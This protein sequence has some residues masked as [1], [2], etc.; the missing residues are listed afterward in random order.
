MSSRDPYVTRVRASKETRD[1]DP[2][3]AAAGLINLSTRDK[4]S[5]TVSTCDQ[6]IQELVTF[7]SRLTVEQHTIPSVVWSVSFA[8][9]IQKLSYK[10]QNTFKA[11]LPGAAAAAPLI[12]T[13]GAQ[14]QPGRSPSR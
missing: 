11:Q 12:P 14:K 6:Q 5:Y 10:L 7:I 8:M 3:A 1:P 13:T 2:Q 9:S 4:E